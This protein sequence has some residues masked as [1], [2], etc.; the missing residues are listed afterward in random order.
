[1]ARDGCGKAEAAAKISSQMPLA[2]KVQLA[3]RVV[4]NSGSLAELQQQVCS[5]GSS[6]ACSCACVQQLLTC[7]AWHG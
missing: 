5:P 2:R 6:L 7:T 1:M 3:D 4:D